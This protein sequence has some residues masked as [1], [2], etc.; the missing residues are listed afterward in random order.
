MNIK[1]LKVYFPFEK[2]PLEMLL[3]IFEYLDQKDKMNLSL[4][5]KW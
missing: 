2:L 1:I 5:S 3:K 4:V